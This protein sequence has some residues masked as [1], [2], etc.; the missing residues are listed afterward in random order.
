MVAMLIKNGTAQQ[1]STV[2]LTLIH[3]ASTPPC[4]DPPLNSKC[5]PALAALKC[6]ANTGLRG[7]IQHDCSAPSDDNNKLL[8]ARPDN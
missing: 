4:I 6:I 8:K 5:S 3:A 1:K 2:T 7:V